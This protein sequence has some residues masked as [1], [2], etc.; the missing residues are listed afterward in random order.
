MYMSDTTKKANAKIVICAKR[1]P[2][3]NQKKKKKKNRNT[4]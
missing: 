4:Y 3:T 1:K 2:G